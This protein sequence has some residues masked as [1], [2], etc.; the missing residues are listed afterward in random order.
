MLDDIGTYDN[1]AFIESVKAGEERLMGF[2]HRVYKN[3]DPRARII[4]DAAYDVFEVTGTNPLLDIALK[5]EEVALSDDYFVDRQA[6]PERRFLQRPDLRVDGLPGR[7]VH[8]VVRHRPN[9]WLARPLERDASA[10]LSNRPSPP[11]LHG[12]GE[13]RDYVAIRRSLTRLRAAHH[14]ANVDDD[15]ARVGVLPIRMCASAMSSIE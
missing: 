8:R 9:P 3:Y 6:L 10:E 1:V 14:G 13:V 11:A 5:L 7:D 12:S 4:K 2:G 15:L